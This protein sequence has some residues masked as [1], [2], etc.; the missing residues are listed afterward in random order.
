MATGDTSGRR[1]LASQSTPEPL[2]EPTD[3]FGRSKQDVDEPQKPRNATRAARLKKLDGIKEPT[4]VH[5][6]Q[7]VSKVK[8]PK[9]KAGLCGSGPQSRTCVSLYE[10]S[11][12]KPAAA[13][14]ETKVASPYGIVGDVLDLRSDVR[15]PACSHNVLHIAEHHHI[16]SL[17]AYCCRGRI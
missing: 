7:L 9:L 1:R 13:A 10:N 14:E 11:V 4:D 8:G 3:W 5:R 12:L 6:R 16:P 2:L 17:F 15:A